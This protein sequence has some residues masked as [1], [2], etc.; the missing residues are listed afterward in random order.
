MIPA[1]RIQS[2]LTPLVALPLLLATTL[3][4]PVSAPARLSAGVSTVALGDASR[5]DSEPSL[6]SSPR[7]PEPGLRRSWSAVGCQVVQADARPPWRG[8]TAA[9]GAG[10]VRDGRVL[11]SRTRGPPCRVS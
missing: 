2:M 10:S 3:D 7:A 4:A 6:E 8:W 5:R 11:K 1:S 9:E